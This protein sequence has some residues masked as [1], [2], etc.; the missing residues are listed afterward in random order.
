MATTDHTINDALAGL[1][2]QIR[3]DVVRKRTGGPNGARPEKLEKQPF[4]R[5]L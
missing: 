5:R 1:L 4:C 2:R 3:H